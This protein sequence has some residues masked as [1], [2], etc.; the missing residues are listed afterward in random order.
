MGSQSQIEFIQYSLELGTLSR[1]DITQGMKLAKYKKSAKSMLKKD[2]VAANTLLGLVASLEHD[3]ASMHAY[4]KK[5]IEISESCF[6]L[7]YYAVSLEKS[8]LWNESA[9]YALLALDYDPV[10]IKLLDA[11]ISVAPLTGR[12]SLLKRLLP[13]W[14]QANNGVPHP[15]HGDYE[16]ICDI[17]SQHGLLEKDLKGVISA[18][19][20]ALSETDVILWKFHYDLVT[21]RH[22]S[23]FI[24]YRF[25]IADQF[26][27][28]YYE[29]LVAAKLDAVA[30]HPRIF[31]AFSF[32]VENSTVYE[33][34]DYME[35]ELD[36]SAD[37]I[38]VPDP[39]KMK[40]IEELVQ[41]VE[42]LTW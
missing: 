2:P 10:N 31:D 19:G 20:D 34:Y 35:K 22:D 1:R 6:S 15:R 17:L 41:G 39:V 33:L 37:T 12:F 18:I 30:C 38:C 25:V 24:H 27:A 14:Q 7:M 3:I 5:A 28:S 32:S 26:V 16:I 36:G 40:L 11:I 29:D 13:Q 9:R 21:E 4:H 8:C 23:S 42:I